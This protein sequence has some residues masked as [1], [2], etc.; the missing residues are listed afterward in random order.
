VSGA[1][2]PSL[3]DMLDEPAVAFVLW[4]RPSGRTKWLAVADVASESEGWALVD[5]AGDWCV[6]LVG[7]EPES[8]RVGHV[9]GGVR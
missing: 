8:A 9:P 7:R 1:S 2:Q 4:H 6:R 3:L 5:R